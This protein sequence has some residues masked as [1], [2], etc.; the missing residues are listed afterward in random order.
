[1]GLLLSATN[2][3]RI[4][5]EFCESPALAYL[6]GLFAL[7]FGLT[8]LVFHQMWRAD[9]TLIITL[10]GWLGLIKGSLLIAYP[11]VVL[12]LS[13]SLL[14]R[15]AALRTWRF[16]FLALGLFLSVKGFALI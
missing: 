6:G 13:Q 10:I 3:Q 7:N 16:V 11:S 12:Q 5:E 15:P 2:F 4:L 14:A 8:I 9:W 1:V